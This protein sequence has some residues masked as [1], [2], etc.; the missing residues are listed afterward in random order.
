MIYRIFRFESLPKITFRKYGTKMKI[1]KVRQIFLSLF[2]RI[3]YQY[4]HQLHQ[5]QLKMVTCLDLILMMQQH[6]LNLKKRIN[7]TMKVMKT[8]KIMSQMRKKKL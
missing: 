5:N 2:L 7:P 4:Y 1:D 3:L 8:M 6:L